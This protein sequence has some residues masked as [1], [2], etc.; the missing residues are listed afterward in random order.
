M[1][2]LGAGLGAG[3]SVGLGLAYRRAPLTALLAPRY[4]RPS[5]RMLHAGRLLRQQD[6]PGRGGEDQHRRQPDS[7][8]QRP[9]HQRQ[10]QQ[11][12][13]EQKPRRHPGDGPFGDL[14]QNRERLSRDLDSLRQSI[15]PLLGRLRTEL[16]VT[17]DNL[18]DRVHA[19]SV[20]LN[21]LTGYDSVEMRKQR[22]AE[23]DETLNLIKEDA[24]RAK[25][26]YEET[27]DDR[28]RV[29][30]ELNSLL[31]RKD[32]W[33]DTDITRFTE[34]YRKDL[35]LEQLESTAQGS[36]KL[37]TE[38]FEKA[39][40][41]YLAE[42]R[43]RYVEE[44]LYSDKIRQAST[45]WTWGL[46][47]THF[48]IFI[49]VQFVVEPR[50]KEAL[51]KEV[52][53]IIRE[54]SERDRLAFATEVNALILNQHQQIDRLTADVS[55]QQHEQTAS[56][57]SLQR[58]QEKMLQKDHEAVDAALR[59]IAAKKKPATT[60]EAVAEL[61]SSAQFWQGACAGAVVSFFSYV[62]FLGR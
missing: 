61:L 1:A 30:R 25:V 62:A 47:T 60:Q 5:E 35:A 28:R 14:E 54:T 40:V 3:L 12:Q 11:Q 51:K 4:I 8:P 45:W 10:Q 23:K 32:T 41:E 44:Q 59:S 18:V 56:Q 6:P 7:E 53:S 31:Q 26:H 24:R 34:L 37:A 38:M 49:A 13:S 22:V 29:Q 52:A 33:S 19:A 46:I 43:E 55:A 58:R 17:K 16:A 36:Y 48:L 15:K 42:I 27:I 50:K 57:Q 9:Q 2:R 20:M 21:R 39:Q